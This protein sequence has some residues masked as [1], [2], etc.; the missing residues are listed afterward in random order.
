[1]LHRAGDGGA[2]FTGDTFYVNPDLRTV[3]VMYSFPNHVPVSAA[4]VRRAAGAVE[5]FA[6]RRIYGAWWGAVIED[7]NDAIR[8]SA[9]RYAAAV[10][11]ATE[12]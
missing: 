5:P 2:L 11:G 1:V 7:G 4:T 8:R 6:F 12:A 10:E 3:G 9:E